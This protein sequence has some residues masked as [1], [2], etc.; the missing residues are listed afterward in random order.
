M[1]KL[2]RH[3]LSGKETGKKRVLKRD[4]MTTKKVDGGV[5]KS[6]SGFSRS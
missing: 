4:K 3:L 5:K 2:G 6:Y 1:R